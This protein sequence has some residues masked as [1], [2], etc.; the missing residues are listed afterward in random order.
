MTMM[1]MT[2]EQVAADPK[3]A[4][5][6]EACEEFVIAMCAS[7]GAVS[8]EMM[9]GRRIKVSVENAD[10]VLTTVEEFVL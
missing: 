3:I 1:K 6:A 8:L 5:F 7:Q 10:E 2:P 4:A 9:D